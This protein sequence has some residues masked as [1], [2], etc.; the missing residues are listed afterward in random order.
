VVEHHVSRVGDEPD[1]LASV[2]ES[3][4][5]AVENGFFAVTH[6]PT[7]PNPHSSGGE[8]GFA[9]RDR[10]RVEQALEKRVGGRGDEAR[11]EGAG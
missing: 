9:Q 10:G 4:S 1:A 6:P 7:P 3:R 11:L 5:G 2:N 8:D